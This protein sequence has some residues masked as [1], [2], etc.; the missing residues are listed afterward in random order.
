[1]GI[2]NLSYKNT[3]NKYAKHTIMI[4]RARPGAGWRWV[5]T[6]NANPGTRKT[7]AK[8][9]ERTQKQPTTVTTWS[10]A[11]WRNSLTTRNRF[12][13]LWRRWESNPTVGDTLTL[14]GHSVFPRIAYKGM[15]SDLLLEYPA[16]PWNPPDCPGLWSLFGH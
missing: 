13:C 6:P 3:L 14:C 15:Q 4:L 11:P 1:M 5:R 2:K 8:S 16:V 7:L 9:T 10:C 12:A